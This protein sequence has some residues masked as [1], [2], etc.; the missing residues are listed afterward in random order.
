MTMLGVLFAGGLFAGCGETRGVILGEAPL[1]DA[2]STLTADADGPIAIVSGETLTAQQGGA[3]G[4]AYVDICPGNQV[5]IGYQGFLTA[6]SVGLT[7]VG[8]VQTLCGELGLEGSPPVLTTSPG[9]TFPMRGAS[10]TSPWSQLCPA[11]QVVVGFSGGSGL[12]LDQVAFQCASWV[13]TDDGGGEELSPG[14]VVTLTAAGGDTGGPFQIACPSG[15]L[16][17]G[18]NV[19][20]GDWVDSFGLICGSLT[21]GSDGGPP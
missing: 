8:G 7:L 10:Q 1:A 13:V 21:L 19:K 5:V 18:S 14:S 20:A 16:A 2:A 15:Q 12:Y 17:R 4:S 11:G 3:G 9:A 6:P